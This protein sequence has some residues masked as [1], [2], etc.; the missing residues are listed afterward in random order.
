MKLFILFVW[1]LGE[2]APLT[3]YTDS[4]ECWSAARDLAAQIE[5]DTDCRLAVTVTPVGSV[6]L[7][8]EE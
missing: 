3:A 6:P 4:D 7:S 2:P 8:G 5:T 1:V